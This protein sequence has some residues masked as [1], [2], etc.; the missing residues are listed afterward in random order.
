MKNSHTLIISLVLIII[1]VA[2]GSSVSLSQD[3]SIEELYFQGVDLLENKK[4]YEKALTYFQQVIELDP[5]H[6]EAHFQIGKIFRTTRQ[7][8]KAITHYKNAI[9]LKPDYSSAYYE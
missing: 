8:E 7:F 4:Q 2:L 9:N 3:K 5:D 6:A 1:F